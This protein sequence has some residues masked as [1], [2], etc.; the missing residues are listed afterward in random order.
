[1]LKHPGTRPIPIE[2]ASMFGILTQKK[3]CTRCGEWKSKKEFSKDNRTKEGLQSR[4]KSCIAELSREFRKNHPDKVLA[5]NRAY[6]ASNREKVNESGRKYRAARP[7]VHRASNAKW[8][9]NNPDKVNEIQE[10]SRVKN[11]E[12]INLKARLHRL[13]FP[14]KAKEAES[15]WLKSH[16]EVHARKQGNRRARLKGSVGKITAAEIESL[17][18]K[19]NYTC[20]C[21]LRREPE[22]EL[23]HDHVKPL[24]MGGDNTIENSQ[25]L[26]RSCNSRKG[27]K[28]IDYR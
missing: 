3:Q 22:I 16:P 28:W 14:E 9:R 5:S 13:L 4:C 27:A 25:M 12:K 18:I 7:E 11:R 17:A 6:R 24:A 21:C 26:C 10:R 8:Q 19:Q 2:E 1:M 20:L 15:K 23:T